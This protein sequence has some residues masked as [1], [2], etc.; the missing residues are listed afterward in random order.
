MGA[1]LLA[2]LLLYLSLVIYAHGILVTGSFNV[3]FVHEKISG[4]DRGG[5]NH[6]PSQ[7]SRL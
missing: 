5:N 1:S 4:H 2:S 3:S 7:H 6:L